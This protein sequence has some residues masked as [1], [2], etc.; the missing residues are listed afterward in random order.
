MSNPTK[1][2]FT[3]PTTNTDGTALPVADVTGVKLSVLTSTGAV[4]ESS[5]VGVASL[6]LD[7]NGNGSIA[8][9]SLPSGT[10]QVVLN[11]EAVSQGVAVESAASAPVSFVV[12]IPSIPNPPSAVS[13]A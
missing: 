10:Y 1:V 4:G 9:P 3:L 8:L 2:V 11:T 13:V 5:V 7:A 12:A 6:N